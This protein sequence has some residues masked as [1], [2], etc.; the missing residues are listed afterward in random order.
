M[1]NAATRIT[2][3]A[4]VAE[5][6]T[7]LVLHTLE[8][9][10]PQHGYRIAT[11]LD[12]F[13][14]PQDAPIDLPTLYATILQQKQRGLLSASSTRTDGRTIRTYALTPRGRRYLK[15]ARVAWDQSAALLGGLIEEQGRQ[16]RELELARQ[17]QTHF[18]SSLAPA[19]ELGLDVAGRYRPVRAVGGDYYDIIRLSDTAV[20]LTL[21]DVSGKGIAAALLMA[22]LR[23]LVRSQAGGPAPLAA[24]MARLNH[25]LLESCTSDR[26]ASLFYAVYDVTQAD[27]RY[28]N[29]GH[30]PPVVL[31]PAAGARPVLLHAGGPVLGLLPDRTYEVGAVPFPAGSLLVAYTDGLT[32]ACNATGSDWGEAGLLAA[33]GRGRARSA[34]ALADH[35]LADV[36]RFMVDEPQLD[37]MTVL[38]ARRLERP[39]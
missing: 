18:V 12:R 19:A 28:V 21:G 26:F 24:L 4:Q 16:R 17:V 35:L 22:T 1:A 3:P 27:L 36:T 38:V 25:L 31:A 30:H 8:T 29:A 23:A 7:V 9:A 6:L 20:A 39:L 14:G 33:I 15:S 11:L 5:A 13:V 10:G 2:A 37:D 34:G 32:E